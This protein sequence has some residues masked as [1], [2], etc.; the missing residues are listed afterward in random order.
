MPHHTERQLTESE[1]SSERSAGEFLA[2]R[3]FAVLT[4]GEREAARDVSS[5]SS[6]E[7]IMRV[8]RTRLTSGTRGRTPKNIG[9][10]DPEV[11][12]LTDAEVSEL[13]DHPSLH[14]RCAEM[15]SCGLVTDIFEGKRHMRTSGRGVRGAI[16]VI[17]P[18]GIS[19]LNF[20]DRQRREI[21]DL[22]RED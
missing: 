10:I 6:Y 12:G 18:V 20:L 15:R 11:C 9:D 22:N 4:P 19:A 1:R 14:R 8:Y 16:S 13:M 3:G 21:E 5:A 17:T 7:K 2:G